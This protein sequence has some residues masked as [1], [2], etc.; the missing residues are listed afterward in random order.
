MM[1]LATIIAVLLLI[2]ATWNAAIAQ[3][4]RTVG[5]SSLRQRVAGTTREA[6]AEWFLEHTDDAHLALSFIRTLM[7]VAVSAAIVIAFA[8]SRPDGATS[9]A[10][11]EGAE[12][13]WLIEPGAAAIG[14]GVS[15]IVLWLTT[16]VLATAIARAA[17]ES[18]VA[19]SLL[20]IR[21]ASLL[22]APVMP[23]IRMLE[24]VISRVA[25]GPKLDADEQAEVELMRSIEQQH[26]EGGLDAAAAEMLGN[27]VQF[28]QTDVGE[29]MTPRTDIDGVEYT[30]D[31][32]VIRRTIAEHGHS[33]MPVYE[34]NLDHLLGVLYVKDL[35]PYLGLDAPGF[36]LRPLLRQPIVVPESK[37]VSELLEEFQRSEVHMAIVVDEYGGTAG[38]VTIEDA[39]EEIVGEIQDEHDTDAEDLPTLD[40]VAEGVY[41]VD[42]RYHVDDLNEALGLELPDTED[43][44]TIAGHVL[45]T[46][47]HVPSPGEVVEAE[48]V[49]ISVLES[50]VT[51]IE[52]LR[53]DLTTGRDGSTSDASPAPGAPVSDGDGA[54]PSAAP[55]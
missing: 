30:D 48:G 36:E 17:G 3:S 14:L 22:V 33:R 34:E 53:L 12:A 49:R 45:A 1:V 27:V 40:R 16:V 35:V 23:A 39:L 5:R 11:L 25:G 32:G 44:D 37:M 24:R 7:R 54:E 31:L 4:V 6:R 50:T 43:Y 18:L 13:V 26:E 21:A 28:N 19:S 55:A 2:P 10:A 42:G 47:G 52:R 9:T 8:V 20:G 38:I 46:L 41:E 15:V 29:V 51:A